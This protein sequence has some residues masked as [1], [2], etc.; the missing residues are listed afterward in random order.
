M[1]LIKKGFSLAELLIAIGIIS[2]IAVMGSSIAK[3]NIE[4][5]YNLYIYTGYKGLIDVV[6]DANVQGINISDTN[7]F[8]EYITDVLNAENGTEGSITTITAPNG[9]KYEFEKDATG[10]F[11]IVE[12]TVPSIDGPVTF[13]L[14]YDNSSTGLILPYITDSNNTS[15]LLL[16]RIDI[17]PFYIDDGEVGRYRGSLPYSAREYFTLREAYCKSKL[18]VPNNTGWDCTGINN[19]NSIDGAPKLIN[20]RKI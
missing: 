7:N 17:L 10:T 2:I 14:M 6:A 9:I 15:Y 19:T 5:A 16:N 11:Y 18:T 4:K 1:K 13:P 12:L 8:F 20:P 3:Q